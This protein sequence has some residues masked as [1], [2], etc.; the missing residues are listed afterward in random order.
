M[1]FAHAEI[2]PVKT[3]TAADVLPCDS[4]G[5][6]RQDARGFFWFCTSEGLVRL[7]DLS[8]RMR[9]FASDTL[10]AQDIT[11]HFHAPQQELHLDAEVRRQVFLIFKECINNIAR[12][13][14]A[15]AVEVEF[16]MPDHHLS[17][18]IKDN[19]RGL[20][21]T[22]QQ[23]GQ[24]GGNGLLSMRRR[25]AELGGSL[26]V[27]SANGNGTQVQLEAPLHPRQQK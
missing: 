5:K 15:T 11:L 21:H 8:Q 2:L 26:A 23:P 27:S 4:V 6:V 20:G 9:R 1:P 17:L 12:H 22:V 16:T 18:R 13:A 10:S 14:N 25:A 19:G 24:N 7:S 3:Y